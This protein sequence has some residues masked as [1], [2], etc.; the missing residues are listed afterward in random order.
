MRL[1]PL[2]SLRGIAALSVVI[3]HCLLVFPESFELL[4]D[5]GTPITESRDWMAALLTLTPPA[6]L[7]SGREAVVLFF[8]LSGFVLALPFISG[9]GPHYIPFAARRAIRLLMPC[10]AVV[11][12]VAALAPFIGR[13]PRPDLSPWV[14]MSWTEPVTPWLVLQHMFLIH[15]LY[16][17][18]NV[19]WTLEYELAASLAFPLLVRVAGLPLPTAAV[20][21]LGAMAVG[22][23]EARLLGGNAVGALT[24]TPHFLLGI[25]LARHRESILATLSSASLLRFIALCALCYVLLRF[26]WI[27]P[28]P[29]A[30][31]DLANGLGAALLIALVLCSPRIQVLLSLRPVVWLGTVSYS[32]YLIHVPLIVGALHLAPQD[33]PPAMVL[34]GVVPLSLLAAAVLHRLVE[35]PSIAIARQLAARLEPAPP[36]PGATATS[37]PSRL[38][39]ARRAGHSRPT[40]GPR[41]ADRVSRASDFGDER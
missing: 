1:L 12:L 16:P 28:L 20:V 25:L 38:G 33:L 32:L 21:G 34:A 7:W 4:F 27:V 24:A 19:L 13:A 15:D 9:R 17:L 36:R 39:T 22:V 40:N 41:R 6:L 26:R 35:L 2:D 11:L 18:N 30:A 3:H 31:C 29:G 8:V 10:I 37:P 5:R 14:G 23:A